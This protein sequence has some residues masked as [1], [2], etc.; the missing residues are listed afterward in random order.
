MKKFAETHEWIV[1]D[2]GKGRIGISTDAQKE[3][4][5]I[6]YIELPRLGQEVK[7]E[8]EVAVLESTKAAVDIYSPVSGKIVAIN[9]KV[10]RNPSL[11]NRF[12][13]GEGYLFELVLSRPEEYEMLI[14]EEK[15]RRS[16]V[17]GARL[18]I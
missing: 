15:Y 4:G 16:I 5:E 3:L 17:S 1:I 2:Q 13:E 6:V 11:I 12:P 10:Q 14:S 7:V 9:E 18:R 8:E